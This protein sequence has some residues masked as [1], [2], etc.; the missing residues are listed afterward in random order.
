MNEHI[1]K[2]LEERLVIVRESITENEG[3]IERY[4]GWV[5]A[6]KEQLN[7]DYEEEAVLVKALSEETVLA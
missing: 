5:Q 4:G 3:Q 1:R 6:A 2:L 7:L